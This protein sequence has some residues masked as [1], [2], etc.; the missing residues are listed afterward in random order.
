MRGSLLGTASAKVFWSGNSLA[1][2]T[3]LNRGPSRISGGCGVAAG[4]SSALTAKE[5]RAKKV[6][7]RVSFIATESRPGWRVAG[8]II[9]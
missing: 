9:G 1:V 3:S 5:E 7:A 8:V 4:A 6:L 2:C